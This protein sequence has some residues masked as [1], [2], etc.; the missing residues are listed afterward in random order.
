VSAVTAGHL[1]RA[2]QLLAEP[3]PPNLFDLA[4][5]V[6]ALEEMLATICD[7]VE[8]LRHLPATSVPPGGGNVAAD[9]TP[10]SRIIPGCPECTAR[11]RRDVRWTGA[12]PG[13]GDS[14]ACGGC[15]ST[16]AT[17]GTEET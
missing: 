7:D 17:P 3:S 8:G 6:G 12:L 11:A 1:A 5:R 13:G 15:G 14:W 10:G 9:V 16:W 4:S 2:R